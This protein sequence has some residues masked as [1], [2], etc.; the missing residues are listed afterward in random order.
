MPE[1]L[2]GNIEYVPTYIFDGVHVVI[3][4][5]NY[6]TYVGHINTRNGI[7]SDF[8]IDLSFEQVTDGE[9]FSVT[10]IVENV[11]GNTELDLVLQIVLTESAIPVNW[12]P[13]DHANFI[14]RLMIPNQNGTALDFS[15]GNTQTITGDFNLSYY[16]QPNC[17]LMAFVQDNST[18]EIL[19]RY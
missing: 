10:A 11:G 3:G 12:P 9:D 17:H 7:M 8:T 5:N 14:N 6:N 18:K 2:M 1:T 4:A 13:N 15:G 19:P 16:D